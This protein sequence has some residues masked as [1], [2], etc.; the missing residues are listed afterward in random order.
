MERLLEQA[1]ARGGRSL[2]IRAG[3]FFGPEVATS[4]LHAVMVKPGRPV[5]SV[6]YPGL[7]DVG[8]AWAYLPDL[9]ETIVAIATIEDRLPSFDVFNFGGHWIEPGIEMARAVC[10]ALGRPEMPIRSMPWNLLRLIAPF[11]SFVRELLDIQYLW[12]FAIRLDNSKLLRLLGAEPH[13]PLDDAVRQ[14][15]GVLAARS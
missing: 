2:V 1:A 4:W 3:D 11:S 13:T 5:R 6:T 7:C 10:R 14:S 15:L 8:H 12:Q 9:A